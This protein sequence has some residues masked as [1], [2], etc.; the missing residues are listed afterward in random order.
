ME[1]RPELLPPQLDDEQVERL[2]E[3]AA[4]LDGF[5]GSSDECQALVE[6]FNREAGTH[7]EF[8]EFQGIYGSTD[9]ET[10]V[11]TILSS[12]SARPIPD[13][14]REELVEVTRRIADGQ[15]KE[16]QVNF[17][18]DLLQANVPDPAVSDLIFWP[19]RY[20]EV[21]DAPDLT[22]DQIVDIALG[23]KPIQLPPSGR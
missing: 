18:L 21:E 4:E 20:F 9:H 14:T 2:A 22:P 7:C 23:Y 19:N 10:W 8:H 6:Q 15:G 1:L 13:V 12:P 16:H 17:W 3:L 11:R 5:G